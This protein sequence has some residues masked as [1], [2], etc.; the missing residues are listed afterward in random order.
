[1][2]LLRWMFSLTYCGYIGEH[3]VLGSGPTGLGTTGEV[4][5][6]YMEK[7]QIQ[8]IKTSPYPLEHWYWYVDDSELKCHTENSERILEH[9][10]A[11][12]KGVIVFT[13]EEQHEGSLPVLDLKQNVNRETGEVECMVHCKKH[14]HQHKCERKVESSTL[15]EERHHTRVS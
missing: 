2:S 14:T 4:A 10:N 5:I 11:I 12:E 3:F 13:K 6:I 8:A 15:H 1:M 9:L 7:F